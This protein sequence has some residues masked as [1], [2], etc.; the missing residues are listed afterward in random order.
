MTGYETVAD[1]A[2]GQPRSLRFRISIRESQRAAVI[3]SMLAKARSFFSVLCVPSPTS[4]EVPGEEREQRQSQP[5]KQRPSC[6]HMIRL[7]VR[8]VVIHR[9]ADA[10]P[11]VAFLVGEGQ[12]ITFQFPFPG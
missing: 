9:K 2:S 11:L 5:L 6:K 1:G 10:P 7:L 4:P 8:L 12:R 3:L